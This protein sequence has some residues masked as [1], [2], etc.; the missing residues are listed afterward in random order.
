MTKFG[1]IK[2]RNEQKKGRRKA[3]SD[4]RKKKEE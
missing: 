3:R 1:E 2:M 4:E